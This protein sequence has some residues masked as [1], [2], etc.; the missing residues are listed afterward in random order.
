[1]DPLDFF[2]P[3]GGAGNAA[4]SSGGSLWDYAATRAKDMGIPLTLARNLIQTES[5][6]DP[7]AQGPDTGKGRGSAKGPTQ[8]LDG[9]MREMGYDPRTATPEDYVD[10]GLGY[11]KKNYERFGSWDKALAAYHAGP[12]AVDKAGGIPD[13]RDVNMSTGDYVARNMRGMG[14]GAPNPGTKARPLARPMADDPLAFFDG[15]GADTGA[16][17]PPSGGMSSIDAVL[18]QAAQNRTPSVWERTKQGV[19]STTRAMALFKDA[20][21]DDQASM[22][23]RIAEGQRGALPASP[24]QR[25]MQAEIQ[26]MAQRHALMTGTDK[27]FSFAEIL[28]KRVQQFA[29]NPHELVASMAENLPNSVPGLLGTLGGSAAGTAVAGPVGTVLGGIAGGTAGG[30]GVEFGSDFEQ[31]VIQ[32]A[33]A[34]GV[35]PRD[36]QALLP[37]IQKNYET[38]KG[39]ALRKGLGTSSTDAL[40]NILT[41]GAAGAGER[42][43]VKEANSIFTDLQ[44]G[45][46][47]ASDAAGKISAM[48][49]ASARITALEAR[50]AARNTLPRK[51]ARG[52]GVAAG[53]MAG[54]SGSEAI[55]EYAADGTIDPVQVIDE[56]LLSLGQGTVMGAGHH[57]IEKVAGVAP[58]ITIE[59]SVARTQRTIEEISQAPD[60]QSAIAAASKAQDGTKVNVNTPEPPPVGDVPGTEVPGTPGAAP[61]AE[62]PEQRIVRLQK[63]VDADSEAQAARNAREGRSFTGERPGATP[64]TEGTLNDQMPQGAPRADLVAKQAEV[65]KRRAAAG[66]G[67]REGLADGESSSMAGPGPRERRAPGNVFPAGDTQRTGI[68]IVPAEPMTQMQ[69]RQRV[70][71]LRDEAKRAGRDPNALVIIPHP[72][73]KGSYAIQDRDQ[74]HRYTPGMQGKTA[75]PG[76]QRTTGRGATVQPGAQATNVDPV[77]AYVNTKRRENTPAAREFVRDYVAGR[78][79]DQDV[80]GLIKN[81]AVRDEQKRTAPVLRFLPDGTPIV[82]TPE[83][84]TQAPSVTEGDAGGESTSMRNA[85]GLV[86]RMRQ[87]GYTLVTPLKKNGSVDLKEDGPNGRTFAYDPDS[88]RMVDEHGQHVEDVDAELPSLAA[89]LEAAMR[90]DDF[91]QQRQPTARVTDYRGVNRAPVINDLLK[92][93]PPIVKP[94]DTET[95]T[96]HPD[97]T[98]PVVPPSDRR[99]PDDVPARDSA[100]N[101][102]DYEKDREKDRVPTPTDMDPQDAKW[103]D[104][105]PTRTENPVL[106]AVVRE[107]NK[108]KIAAFFMNHANPLYRLIGNY[109]NVDAR[110]KFL[111]PERGQSSHGF[112]SWDHVI[113]IRDDYAGNE[114]TVAHEIVHGLTAQ[115]MKFGKSREA[116]AAMRK[117]EALYEFVRNKPGQPGQPGSGRPARGGWKSWYGTTTTNGVFELVAEGFTN[118]DFMDWLSQI[119]YGKQSAWSR[120]VDAI[121]ELLGIP[122]K[123][124]SAL[125]EL[126]VQGQRV[127]ELQAQNYPKIPPGRKP[128]RIR[129]PGWTAPEDRLDQSSSTLSTDENGMPEIR[130]DSGMTLGL[131]RPFDVVEFIPTAD[132]QRMLNMAIMSPQGK[133]LG[134]TNVLFQD[135]KPTAI[136]DIEIDAKGQ[137]QGTEVVKALL[138]QTPDGTLHVSNIVPSARGFWAKLGIGEQN[139]EQGAAYDGTITQESFAAEDGLAHQDAAGSRDATGQSAG[140]DGARAQAV[141]NSPAFKRW[142]AGSR[143]VDEDGKPLV[144]Y[145][146]TRHDFTAFDRNA[147]G[148]TDS[149]DAVG[150]WFASDPASAEP[151]AG[152]GEGAKMMPV[153]LNVQK[154]LYIDSMQELQKLWAEHGDGESFRRGNPDKLRAWLKQQGYDGLILDADEADRRNGAPASDA[155]LRIYTVVLDPEQIKSAF[156]EGAFDPNNPNILASRDAPAD[157]Q[158]RVTRNGAEGLHDIELTRD[159]RSIGTA[160]VFVNNGEAK[161]GFI[162]INKR[163]RGGVGAEAMSQAVAAAAA[164]QP[165]RQVV[166][167]AM[168]QASLRSLIGAFGEPTDLTDSHTGKTLTREQ[169]L[170]MLPKEAR[171]NEQGNLR[172]HEDDPKVWATFNY[173]ANAD[174]LAST[175]APR[176][177]KQLMERASDSVANINTHFAM[178]NRVM[179]GI[180]SAMLP[181]RAGEFNAFHKTVGT[182]FHKAQLNPHFAR[183]FHLV[184]KFI[185]DNSL[186]ANRAEQLARTIFPGVS[187]RVADLKNRGLNATENA[188]LGKMLSDGTLYGDGKTGK[189]YNPSPMH[190]RV[191]SDEDLKKRYNA[192]DREIQAYKEARAAINQSLTDYAKSQMGAILRTVAGDRAEYV[193]LIDHVA[194]GDLSLADSA[195]TFKDALALLK[196]EGVTGTERAAANIAGLA[197]TARYLQARG[198]APLKRF[199]RIGVTA[200]NDKGKVVYF[201]QVNN[202]AEARALERTLSIEPQISR[203]EAHEMDTESWKLFKGMN[204]ETAAL[205]AEY[206]GMAEADGVKQYLQTALGDRSIMKRMLDRKGTAG[207]SLD[208][209]R[210]LANYITG[211]ARATSGNLNRYA[212]NQAVLD[213]RLKGSAKNEAA[214]LVKYVEDPSDE[215]VKLRS[216][217]FFQYLGGSLASGIVNLTQPVLMT[218]PYLSQWGAGRA[219]NAMRAATGDTISFLRGQKAGDADMEA[220]LQWAKDQGHLDPHE[221]YQLM[222]AAEQGAGSFGTQKFMRLWGMNFQ[223][224]EA[225]NRTLTFAAAF[226]VAQKMTMQERQEAMHTTED[227]TPEDFAANAIAETQGLYNKG[228]RPNWARGAVGSVVFTFKQ[229]TI[230]YLEFL[231]R[232]WGDGMI[233]KKAF[234]VAIGMLVL[235]AGVG[236]LPFAEDL[237]DVIDSAGHLLGYATNTKAWRQELLA[238]YLG[239]DMAK[240]VENGLPSNLLGLDVSRRLG[241]GNV[242]PGTRLLDPAQPA[243]QKAREIADVAGVAGGAALNL[244]DAIRSAAAGDVRGV[245]LSTAPKMVQDMYRAAE[246]AQTGEYRDLKG[247]K[248]AD[249]SVG[250]AIIKGVG[251]QP[252]AV[253]DQQERTRMLQRD[254]DLVKYEQEQFNRRYADAVRDDD[255]EA[256]AKVRE[257][258]QNWNS[259][260]PELPI[261][262][263]LGAIRNRIKQA[264]LSK[265]DRFVKSAPKQMRQRLRQAIED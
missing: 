3:P 119:P 170:R 20:A 56:G 163:D 198:Y 218:F 10:A 241:V 195:A 165:V 34:E 211:N 262:L 106:A 172:A 81:E 63:M 11:L 134:W 18:E 127:M 190:G 131:A 24:A 109:L 178:G 192:T 114:A 183:V 193:R 27:L 45:A 160:E 97:D 247:S 141:I 47:S 148:R 99:V 75:T 60:V 255:Q 224:T 51:L 113:R 117:L 76:Q 112:Y 208:A 237:E 143:M 94:T 98:A 13:T 194:R 213:D 191:W 123:H 265:E 259:S 53:E 243:S 49:A 157:V 158:A 86:D 118:R 162:E 209:T 242:V 36:P 80:M 168:S 50:N 154:P 229:F 67:T 189:D 91:D 239:K 214:R 226:R 244:V 29:R 15:G 52:G 16:N 180:A 58:P 88:G 228:N 38:W 54:E 121:L 203:T 135:G 21:T 187:L 96:D 222:A 223:L 82:G 116:K 92:P 107:R 126:L 236:G 207:Y 238:E 181:T 142:F 33:Q 7:Y 28:A 205:F 62:T 149:I 217:L 140:G 248:V 231:K 264:E 179:S 14:T 232:L 254:V 41:I 31:R 138:D 84:G 12:G 249:A 220:A 152:R 250:D 164:E 100:V 175:T 9:T 225:F 145:H 151:F 258:L 89:A 8:V 4:P 71:V 202:M 196:S 146:G 188:R 197:E 42:A 212:M 136:Y 122:A 201:E 30:T 219:A 17:G 6:G 156:N 221:L 185:Q 83:R 78:I 79:S 235:A 37:I 1:M 186:F 137:G 5:S 166:G 66:M 40:F 200:F 251:F 39:M 59:D 139:V 48:E 74:E 72:E 25:E 147:S 103:K 216:L 64:I 257:D 256:L 230:A 260:N 182:Q 61:A 199:G 68:T 261:K 173:G 46:M 171:Q 110:L 161:L 19:S 210:T 253:A 133:Y 144:M 26:P 115:T 206:N 32:Q 104:E 43:L 125:S 85:R 55:G 176:D 132:S 234:G 245:A 77:Q 90:S 215:A 174:G 102:D 177:V 246:M 128:P 233:P 167:E 252:I 44:T 93:L 155:H 108:D 169:A 153:Y 65:D 101:P 240:F 204:V 95:P 120:F 184:Q 130:T 69:A 129:R 105:L 124:K 87:L 111:P 70:A 227:V 57:A 263:N 73:V 35:D 23:Q 159:G 2:A 22:A 150:S